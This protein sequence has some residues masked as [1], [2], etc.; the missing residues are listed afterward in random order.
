MYHSFIDPGS[1]DQKYNVQNDA[2]VKIIMNKLS[3]SLTAFIIIAL[4]VNVTGDSLSHD[5]L[6]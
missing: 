6:T 2:K 3:N 4:S 1:P 5:C